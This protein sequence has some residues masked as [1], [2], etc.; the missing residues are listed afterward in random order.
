MTEKR[1]YATGK[2]KCA[3]ARIYMKEGSG[4]LTVNKRNFDDYFTRD[5]L[6]MIIQ[7]PIELVGKKGKFDFFINVN[8]GGMAGQAGAVKHGISRALVEY[9]L[10]LRSALKKA[11]FLTRD[12][13]I[14][15]RKKYGQPGA[16]KRFQ[17]SKR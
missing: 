14:K 12:S 9:D 4:V 2:R 17:F 10:A 7:Q 6:K 5:S 15:E 1:F 13:R 16:R 11:G 3:I 8:G